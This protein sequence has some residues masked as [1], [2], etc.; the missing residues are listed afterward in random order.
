VPAPH[1]AEPLLPTRAPLSAADSDILLVRLRRLSPALAD[2]LEQALVDL[3]DHARLSYV[4]PA[5]EV[6]EVMRAT[7]QQ[8][9]PDAE[10]RKQ[11]W[12]VGIKQGSKTN[13]TQAERTRYAV[14]LRGGD[15]DQVK[16][17]DG[18]IDELVGQIGRRTYSVGSGAFHAGT[19][20]QAV[21][22]L[23]R[24]IFAVLDEVLP[25]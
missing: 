8:L 23:T 22:K 3:N 18:L 15:P 14:Q 4:G 5:G 6:R 20:Q 21:R 16:D 1:A 17:V 11:S 25:D 12:F 10:V 7:I 2:S 9:S 24:W 19:Q 13:P